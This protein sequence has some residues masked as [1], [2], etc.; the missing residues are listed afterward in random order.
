MKILSEGI[1]E[2][3]EK[4][5]EN[6]E[7]SPINQ[8]LLELN[9][10]FFSSFDRFPHRVNHINF[11]L[12]HYA[13]NNPVRYLDPDGRAVYSEEYTEHSFE[14]KRTAENWSKS[15]Y[16]IKMVKHIELQFHKV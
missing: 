6:P 5:E 9:A 7:V 1:F 16:V 13:G 3:N 15:C 11:N 8:N 14:G 4:K 2:R 12:Y 10:C